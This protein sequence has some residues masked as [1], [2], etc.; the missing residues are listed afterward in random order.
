MTI[1]TVFQ[2]LR[3]NCARSV[4]G[5]AA[6]LVLALGVSTPGAAQDDYPNRP[7]TIILPFGTGGVS[8]IAARTLAPHLEEAF[9]QRFIVENMPGAAGMVATQHAYEG[10]NE[11]DT[12]MNAGNSA[13]IRATTNPNAPLSQIDD[14]DPVSP[15]GEFGLVIVGTPGSDIEN[16]E[17][18]VAFAR[19]NP[20][21]LNIGTVAVG[22]TQHLSALLFT[23]VAEIDA[24]VIPF[25]NSP[26]VMGA[27]ARGEVDVAF[28]IVAGAR[29]AI[30]SG[31]V[32]LLG[33]TMARRSAIYPDA[34]TVEESGVAPFD[35]SSWN[36]Y[37]AP[38]GIPQDVVH[39]LNTEI[40]RIMAMPEVRE[41]FLSYGIEPY[42]GDADT[43]RARM[44]SDTA[45][46]REV[47]EAAGL[48]IE[49]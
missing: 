22:S 2:N 38:K 11:G 45:K 18:M 30:D 47:I 12:L 40:Q 5:A 7:V 17:D 1:H 24:A 48:P 19:E 6:A 27:V 36:S 14:F 49:N 13:T 44:A 42:E 35:V 15:V 32:R 10:D 31:Q 25:N 28:E 34:P 21:V 4:A 37:V 9:G 33:T 39:R 41:T 3:D 43:V 8:D 29:N 46:W 23:T 26:E 20:G 16:V